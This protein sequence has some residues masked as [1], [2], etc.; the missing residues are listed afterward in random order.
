MECRRET[1]RISY[2]S[3]VIAV[4]EATHRRVGRDD[5]DSDDVPRGSRISVRTP[6]RRSSMVT[7]DVI[8]GVRAEL[9]GEYAHY[10]IRSRW[11]PRERCAGGK[12]QAATAP[13][14]TGAS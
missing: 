7:Y 14:A 13:W 10:L 11:S 9:A 8:A 2:D 5:I 6:L 4:M 3:S 12:G 1:V